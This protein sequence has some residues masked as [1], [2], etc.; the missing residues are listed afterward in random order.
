M[1]DLTYDILREALN[2]MPPKPFI[3]TVKAPAL[4]VCHIDHVDEVKAVLGG[5]GIEVKGSRYVDF[6]MVYLIQGDETWLRYTST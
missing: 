1:A 4:V 6:D 2:K 5:P 3:R